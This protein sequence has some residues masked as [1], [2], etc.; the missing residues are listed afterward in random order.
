MAAVN[1]QIIIGHVGQVNELKSV[2]T[3]KALINF[4][5][6]TTFGKDDNKKTEWHN[7]TAWEKQAE[8]INKYVHKGDLVYVEGRTQ[9]TVKDEKRFV[10]V[11]VNDLKLLHS[12]DGSSN[13]PADAPSNP[14]VEAT[15][16]ELV[17]IPF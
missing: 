1:K 8:F 11:I 13:V 6:A 12:K 3:G 7:C 4:S 15:T 2:G 17:D 16:A 10:N 14:G 5:V 9:T